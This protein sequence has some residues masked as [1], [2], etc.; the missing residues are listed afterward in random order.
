MN[1]CS[2]ERLE[3]KECALHNKLD[4]GNARR[5]DFIMAQTEGLKREFEKKLRKFLILLNTENSNIK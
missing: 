1:P 3:A 4:S 2:S 5:H